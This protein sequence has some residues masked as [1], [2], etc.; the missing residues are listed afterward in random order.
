MKK[1]I[2]ISFFC[3][4]YTF[5]S[6]SNGINVQKRTEKQNISFVNILQTVNKT[7]IEKMSDSNSNELSKHKNILFGMAVSFTVATFTFL[8]MAIVLSA[9][10]GIS[11][12]MIIDS[13]NNNNTGDY[14]NWS[15]AQTGLLA[16]TIAGWSLFTLF[17]VCGIATGIV[18]YISDPDF[19]VVKKKKKKTASIEIAPIG[20]TIYMGFK[21]KV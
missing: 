21:F 4:M 8:V 16:G 15:S 2:F 18:F 1:I 13:S 5:F 3:L 19:S 17:A 11:G 12:K 6:F 14:N 10:Y 9:I 20:N 7:G